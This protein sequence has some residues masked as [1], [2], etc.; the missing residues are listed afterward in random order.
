[1]KCTGKFK[2]LPPWEK[3]AAIVQRYLAFIFFF[4]SFV[5]CFR[6]SIPTGWEAYSFTTVE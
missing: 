3:R 1:M 5:Q 6:V 4:F 2:L